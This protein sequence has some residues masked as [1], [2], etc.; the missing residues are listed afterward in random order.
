MVFDVE[1][2][3]DVRAVAVDGERFAF[4]DFL[5]HERDELLRELVRAVIVGAVCSNY[6]ELVSV[7]VGAC[8]V[9][10]SGFGGAVGAVGRVGGGFGK[11]GIVGAK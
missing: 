7:G 2:I 5:D 11:G 8:E 3:A 10:A 6:G 4:E 1:P 9:I